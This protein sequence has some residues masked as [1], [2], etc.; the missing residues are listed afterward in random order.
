MPSLRGPCTFAHR[1]CSG[2]H[3]VLIR[4]SGT[5]R[6]PRFPADSPAVAPPVRVV[7]AS[8]ELL[9]L[10]QPMVERST[11]AVTV[12]PLAPRCREALRA[13]SRPVSSKGS[14]AESR[15]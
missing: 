1:V 4:R 8:P 7:T 10:A 15:A 13:T 3:M 9:P 11:P 12:L 14:T 2:L 5:S 6:T